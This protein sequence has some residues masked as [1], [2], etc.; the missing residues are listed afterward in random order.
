MAS[1]LLGYDTAGDECIQIAKM[2]NFAEGDDK[3]KKQ[4]VT[5]V[6][7]WRVEHYDPNTKRETAAEITD[8][9][10][11][12][13]GMRFDVPP[14]EAI[15]YFKRKKVLP[16]DEFYKLDAEARSGAFAI[17]NVYKTDV[18]A[19]LQS[20]LVNAL[21][22]GRPQRDVISRLKSILDGAGHKTLSTAHLE[23]VVRTTTQMAYGVGRRIAQEEA[24]DYLPI[25]EYSAVGDDR[26]RPSHMALDGV[27]FPANHSFWNKY[28]PPWDFR[29]RCTVIPT[30]EY[31]AGYDRN[32]PNPDTVLEYNKEGLPGSWNVAGR[33]GN[34]QATDFVGVP[35]QSSLAAVLERGAKAAMDA[36]V[37]PKALAF[38]SGGSITRFAEKEFDSFTKSITEAEA[39]SISHYTS[40]ASNEINNHLRG[41]P[42]DPDGY[43]SKGDIKAHIRNLDT[44]IAKGTLAVDVKAYR[45]FG[46]PEPLKAGDILQD[47]GFVSSSLLKS[48]SEGWPLSS[49]RERGMIPTLIDFVIPKGT[50]VGYV[51][52]FSSLKGE[53]EMLLARGRKF[54]ILSSRRKGDVIYAKARLKR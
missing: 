31:R 28:Y 44:A 3:K 18:T 23:T 53:Y 29:C 32:R 8:G 34:I 30:F 49:A 4:T 24:A 22:T 35:P 37:S 7:K 10:S 48:V 6:R 16:A 14:Q 27:Q 51:E 40:T 38:K 12:P 11:A 13:F 5:K 36:R 41:L 26:T 47:E 1:Y 21:E 54:E 46:W 33:T 17:S 25:W 50:K 43:Y 9:K 2:A 42:H 45:G 39:D 20:E 15:D 19:A 52:A